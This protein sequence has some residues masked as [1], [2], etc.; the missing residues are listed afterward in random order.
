MGTVGNAFV[1]AI[2][3]CPTIEPGRGNVV[4]GT[5]H[6]EADPD[7]RILQVAFSNG[8]IIEGVTDNHPFWSEDRQ[9][10]VPVG[11]L[12]NGENVRVNGGVA[13]VTSVTSR[14]A[15]PGEMLYNL[16]VHNEHVYQVTTAGILVH[17]SCLNEGGAYDELNA[18]KGPGEVAH[19]MPQNAAEV[20]PRGKGPAL[21]MTTEDH[22][23][24]RTFSGRGRV[25][26]AADAD[27]APMER[28]NLDVQDIRAQFGNKYDTG[29]QQ[30][31]DYA[32]TLPEFR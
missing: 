27:L 26:N 12:R 11:E 7:T 20:V 28:L 29:I 17:N 25:T 4:T 18:R 2:E 8:V 23:M 16:E 30:M 10:F 14:F 22:A 5:F 32:R 19:H 15:Y 6:H 24:T 21:G 13:A 1:E 9:T 3:P 31:L